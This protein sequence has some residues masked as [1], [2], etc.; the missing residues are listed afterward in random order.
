MRGMYIIFKNTKFRVKYTKFI[1]STN[2]NISKVTV[3]KQINI[4]GKIIAS[5]TFIGQYFTVEVITS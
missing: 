4:K 2:N 3:L 5:F 1:S